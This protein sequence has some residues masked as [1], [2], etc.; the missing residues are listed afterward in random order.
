M[1]DDKPPCPED[2]EPDEIEAIKSGKITA[3]E[4]LGD[5]WRDDHIDCVA[6]RLTIE[7]RAKPIDTSL[8]WC[9]PVIIGAIRYAK[10]SP[11]ALVDVAHEV[12]SRF[13]GWEDPTT[14]GG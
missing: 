7:G 13:H 11:Q 4:Q 9:G 5:E 10:E 3:V 12:R 8:W 6:V 1:D 14:N 2:L